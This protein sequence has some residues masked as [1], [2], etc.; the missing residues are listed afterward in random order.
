MD[1]SLNGR[2]AL[3]T[4]GSLGLGLAMAKSF[5]SEGAKVAIIARRQEPINEAVSEISMGAN[6]RSGSRQAE[7]ALRRAQEEQK[8]YDLEIAQQRAVDPT[9]LAV[10]AALQSDIARS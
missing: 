7:L 4:G 8:L 1:T 2:T 5:Y 3:I 6:T 9:A 10:R